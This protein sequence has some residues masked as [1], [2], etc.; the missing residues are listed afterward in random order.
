MF[1]DILGTTLGTENADGY[2]PVE[3]SS[4]G[5]ASP[6]H[7]PTSSP[8]RHL[9]TGKPEVD[10]LGHAFLFRNYRAGLGK[11]QTADPL[12]YPDGWNQMAYCGNVAILHIDYAGG[13]DIN[14]FPTND[15][16]WLYAENYNDEDYI[17]VSGHGVSEGVLD[18]SGKLLPVNN[19]ANQIKGLE[20]Y[21]E[22]T[23][24]IL[25]VC[26]VG[27]G[28]YAQQLADILK[29]PVR[30]PNSEAWYGTDGTVEYFKE[31]PNA[32]PPRPDYEN[33]GQ[34]IVFKPSLIINTI[35]FE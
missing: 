20:K 5:D 34:L 16:M 11:W 4:F 3:L 15:Y 26:N 9:F 24:V 21:N 29:I 25:A 7:L 10:G 22:V 6:S 19:L 35:I 32:Y 31:L 17:T 12:G 27:L 23:G 18:P 14:L 8:S 33:P 28:Q 1:N 2:V 30:A 13:A